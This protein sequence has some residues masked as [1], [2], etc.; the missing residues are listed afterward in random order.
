VS[1]R[2]R[3]IRLALE[4][5]EV[6]NSDMIRSA[7]DILRAAGI[8]LA[9]L[10]DLLEAH[11]QTVR[12]RGGDWQPHAARRKELAAKARAELEAMLSAA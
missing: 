12:N 5:L 4:Q 8:T 11:T 7:R 9:V 1:D 2:D 6:V 10:D 3:A